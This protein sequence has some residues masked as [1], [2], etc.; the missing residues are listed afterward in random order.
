[1]RNALIDYAPDS[2]LGAT[3]Q[4][5]L[6]EASRPQP[7]APPLS[8]SEPFFYRLIQGIRGY[9]TKRKCSAP[10]N[11][12]KVDAHVERS[13]SSAISLATNGWHPF[14]DP[15]LQ[16][17]LGVGSD[18]PRSLVELALGRCGLDLACIQEHGCIRP[19]HD[20]TV[21]SLAS[22]DARSH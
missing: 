1:M 14:L 5:L 6:C 12:R 21:Y 18:H 10:L 7:R 3:V 17:D 16:V 2:M 8:R 9:N 15:F 4:R 13:I 22:L 11:A 19:S 20:V